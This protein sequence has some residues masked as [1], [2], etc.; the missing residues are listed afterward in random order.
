MVAKLLDITNQKFGL[1]TA[2]KATREKSG[3]AFIW[4]F[5][6]DCGQICKVRATRVK[7]GEIQSCGCHK[8]GVLKQNRSIFPKQKFGMLTA[9]C[10]SDTSTKRRPKWLFECDCSVIK[11]IRIGHV[12]TGHTRSCGCLHNKNKDHFE[13]FGRSNLPEYKSWRA[14]LQ[15][16]YNINNDNYKYYGGQK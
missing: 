8:N 13:I 12:I 2:I 16:C 5:K 15:R 10:P 3:S 1:L 9:I 14:M 4:E 11:D 6:C 7:R